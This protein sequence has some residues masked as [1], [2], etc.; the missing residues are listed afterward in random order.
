MILGVAQVGIHDNFFE[1]GGDSIISIQVIAQ[2]VQV[3]LR[4]HPKTCSRT[5]TVAELAGK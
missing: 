2:A 3:G 4:L 5:F 1:L